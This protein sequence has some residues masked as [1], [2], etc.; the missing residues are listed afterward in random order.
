MNLQFDLLLCV[1][2]KML[3][4]LFVVSK[5]LQSIFIDLQQTFELFKNTH[6]E[7]KKCKHEYIDNS[8]NVCKF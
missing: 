2:E 5:I 8:K 1:W 4:P 3:K 7:I 6:A